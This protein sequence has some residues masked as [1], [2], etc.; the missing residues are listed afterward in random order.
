MNVE[1][2]EVFIVMCVHGLKRDAKTECVCTYE[3][4]N[5]CTFGCRLGAHMCWLVVCVRESNLAQQSTIAKAAWWQRDEERPKEWTWKLRK[6]DVITDCVL[7]FFV[8]VIFR[9][10]YFF[11]I[12]IHSGWLVC[13]RRSKAPTPTRNPTKRS[14]SCSYQCTIVW[15]HICALALALL[16]FTY[17]QKQLIVA[18]LLS[19][20]VCMCLVALCMYAICL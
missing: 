10:F 17:I 11:H 16:Y 13:W 6:R 8:S 9:C 19:M 12:H 7:F 2:H 4:R 5:F 15:T 1:V 3:S 20:I 18:S 14:K